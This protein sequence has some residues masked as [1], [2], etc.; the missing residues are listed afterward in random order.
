MVNL[1]SVAVELYSGPLNTFT[2]DRKRAG[3]EAAAEGD[4]SAAA[5]IRKLTKPS[6][7]AWLANAFVRNRPELMA[8][9][10]DLGESLEAAQ[11][12]LDRDLLVELTRRRRELLAAIDREAPRLAESLGERASAAVV[13]EVHEA[14]Q[15][16]IIDQAARRAVLS[17]LLIRTSGAGAWK[18]ATALPVD[19]IAVPQFGDAARR[20][21]AAGSTAKAQDTKSKVE[22]QRITRLREEAANIQRAVAAAQ[23][24]V[25]DL[26]QEVGETQRDQK[27]LEALRDD[28]RKQL[29]AAERQ[30]AHAD[31]RLT[32]SADRLAQAA[33]ELDSLEAQARTVQADLGETD[34]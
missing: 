21:K 23:S 14:M 29:A 13:G 28:L 16:A 22:A 9:V 2:T 26:E 32:S 12:A 10:A 7:A 34:R 5:T 8:D 15:A 33:S 24:R 6:V 17:G 3:D 30:L 31:E 18:N 19:Q 20:P 27:Q 4:P 25:A 11:S 1:H